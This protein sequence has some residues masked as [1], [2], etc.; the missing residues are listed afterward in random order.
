MLTFDKLPE[1]TFSFRD[2]QGKYEYTMP[3]PISIHAY[4]DPAVLPKDKLLTTW[5][6]F[7]KGEVQKNF[8]SSSPVTQ[9]F[10]ENLRSAIFTSLHVGLS[11]D[12]DTNIWSATGSTIFKLAGAKSAGVLIRIEGSEPTNQMRITVRSSDTNTSN[13]F[14]YAL[15]LQLQ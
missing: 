4:C 15:V 2:S 13:A 9:T 8:V 3:I 1:I 10:I 11:P 5:H 12:A 14:M 6:S 7:E